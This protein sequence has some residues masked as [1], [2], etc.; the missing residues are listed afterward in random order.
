[1]EEEKPKKKRKKK[2]GDQTTSDQTTRDQT[3]PDPSY[4]GGE[5]GHKKPW[6]EKYA[7]KKEIRQMLSDNVFL[8]QNA[9]TGR[10]EFRVPMSDEF[11]A[12][13]KLYYPSG[14][15]PLDEWRSATRWY[16]VCDRFVNSLLQ[17]FSE[18][19]E[20]LERDL[21]SVIGSDFVPLYNPFSEYLDR[22]PPPD[23]NRAAI[24]ELAMTVTV[25][26]G[27]DEQTLFYLYLRKWLVGMGAGWVNEN[28]V[29]EII[30][31]LVGRQGIYKTTWFNQ[32][33][34]PALK[35]YFHSNANIGRMDKDEVLKLSRYALI[36]CEEIDVLRPAEMNRLK[37]AVT[38]RFT[39][40]RK[41][42][43]HF[44][45]RQEHIATFCGTGN[46]LQ[47]ID[48]PS[49]TRRWLPFEVE[50]IENPYDHPI[51]HDAVF[52]EA[53]ELYRSGF[54]YWFDDD[55]KELKAHN[56]QFEVPNLEKEQIS[57]FYRVPK[58]NERGEFVS[59]A[60]ILQT[61]SYN[62]YRDITINK[63]GRA[64]TALGFRRVRSHNI[65]GYRVV[66]YTPEEIKGNKSL[67]A[68]DA[69]DQSL[70]SNDQEAESF[71]N[72]ELF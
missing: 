2:T 23:K 53:Y 16:P 48:D 32:L 38:A 61:I 11:D 34:P 13:G 29:N 15:S 26:G 28:V 66:T 30:L 7:T 10:P 31:V 3:T 71:G 9:I 63:M 54:K 25:K 39:E 14:S 72:S 59:S 17:L 27:T 21:W 50:S 33:L 51:D 68:S 67:L 5:R 62:L 64:M 22:L 56:E 37:W 42:Y 47:F 8:R 40:E 45:E 6:Q 58:G 52:A 4:S 36:C 43:A 24:F 12:A 49:G 55:D 41:P 57:R 20:I 44:P 46:N 19:K 65:W 1:M 60:E 69:D 35:P 70:Q 18:W